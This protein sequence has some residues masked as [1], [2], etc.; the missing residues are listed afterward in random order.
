MKTLLLCLASACLVQCTHRVADST[1]P[2]TSADNGKI[3]SERYYEI[4]GVRKV[5]R[6]IIMTTTPR[7]ETRLET[8]ILR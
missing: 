8:E 1:R 4:G 7:L 5:E 6:R 2:L 3:L